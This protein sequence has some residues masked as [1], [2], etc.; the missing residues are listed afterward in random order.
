MGRLYMIH[1]EEKDYTNRKVKKERNT[2]SGTAA[3][4]NEFQ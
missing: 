4:S 1:T 2:G 3:Q